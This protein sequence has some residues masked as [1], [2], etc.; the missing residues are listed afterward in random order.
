MVQGVFFRDTVRRIA[1]RY[2]VAGFVRNVGA[3]VL[4]IEAEGESQTLR[5]FI[6]DVLENP[7]R[8]ARIEEVLQTIVSPTGERGFTVAP[9]VR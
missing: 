4:E 8:H 5:A 2:D 7:P 1:R 3:R 6:N 9:S